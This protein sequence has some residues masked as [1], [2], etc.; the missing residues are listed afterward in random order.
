VLME[1]LNEHVS[2]AGDREFD[3]RAVLVGSDG[4]I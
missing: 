2:Y 3:T 1:E 4:W